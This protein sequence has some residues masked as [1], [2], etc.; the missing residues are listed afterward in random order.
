MKWISY[1][2]GN[3]VSNICGLST[4][5]PNLEC[6]RFEYWSFLHCRI[7]HS[8]AITVI[9]T[10]YILNIICRRVLANTKGMPFKQLTERKFVSVPIGPANSLPVYLCWCCLATRR[11]Y[12][13]MATVSHYCGCEH[14]STLW[15]FLLL[16]YFIFFLSYFFFFKLYRYLYIFICNI[17]S[18]LWYE[19]CVTVQ[20]AGQGIDIAAPFILYVARAT[21]LFASR[22]QN[23]KEKKKTKSFCFS[24]I[25]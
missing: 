1:R 21:I 25:L 12:V 20:P 16:F 10:Y 6:S 17:V 24:S 23:I 4:Y 22:T 18:I 9:S 19:I 8:L 3:C 7:A 15:A 5:P 14:I 2:F 13:Y 11:T